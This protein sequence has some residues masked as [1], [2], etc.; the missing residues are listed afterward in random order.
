MDKA[1]AKKI[2]ALVVG[3]VGLFF[4][5]AAVAVWFTGS[6]HWRVLGIKITLSEW[7]KPFA[8]GMSLLVLRGLV[9]DAPAWIVARFAAVFRGAAGAA[10]LDLSRGAFLWLAFGTLLGVTGGVLFSWHYYY[11]FSNL[12]NGLVVGLG[13]GAL[14]GWT[15]FMFFD[16]T[17]ILLRRFFHIA[18]E[19]RRSSIRMSL[20]LVFWAW[21]I[22]GPL[23]AWEARLTEPIVSQ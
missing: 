10:G 20:Y 15:H 19:S 21:L 18:S 12:G 7:Q 3:L 17:E 23:E 2:I 11:L 16:L 5:G 14:V 4:A 8:I 6:H 9:A 22:T 1:R 13:V